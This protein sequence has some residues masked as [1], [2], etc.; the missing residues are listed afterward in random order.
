LN[1]TT[2]PRFISLAPA[3]LV[4]GA[5]VFGQQQA[6]TANGGADPPRRAQQVCG[7][8]RRALGPDG[9][10]K[11]KFG[12]L[13]GVRA[14]AAA[15]PRQTLMANNFHLFGTAHIVILVAVVALAALLAWIQRRH[16]H[17]SKW[18][19]IGLGIFLLADGVGWYVY[20]AAIGQHVFPWQLP[21][22]L[23][24]VVVYLMALVLLRGSPGVFDVAYYWA[25]AGSTMALL[26]PNL[27]EHF[28]SVSTVQFFVAHG[29][30]VSAALYLVWSGQMRPRR[31]SVLRAMIAVNL[32]A[33][34]DGAFDAVFKTDYMYLRFKPQNVS[35]LSY[36]GPW[37]WY[38]LAAEPVALGLFLV[39]Y[40]PF[41]RRQ[42]R[43]FAATGR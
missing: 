29:L 25:L 4:D 43:S 33:L 5:I 39:L 23:C 34:F 1:T 14:P 42:D 12:G 37:P 17:E 30:V 27:W 11:L 24:N 28:P 31:G 13:P 10:R 16:L 40:W 6:C 32:L 22:E 3:R 8:P 9:G 41:R 36:L 2:T 19:R 20:L 7:E 18:L 38:V 21:L 15:A 26:T 35:L